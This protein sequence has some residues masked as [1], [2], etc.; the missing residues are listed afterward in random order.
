MSKTATEGGHW[1]DAISG[2]PRYTIIGKNGK[3]RNTNLGDARKLGLVPSVTTVTKIMAAPGL[4]HYFKRQMFDATATTP[5]DQG[6]SDDDYFKACCKWAD[7]HAELARNAGTETHGTIEKCIQT[8]VV[9]A[10]FTDHWLAI[11]NTLSLVNVDVTTG[12]A[13]HSF[14][15][16]LGYGGKVD[17][18]NES[19]VLDFKTKD[20]IEDGKKLAWDEH[21]MQLAAYAHG[22]NIEAPR[23]LN[24]FVGITDGKVVVHE[25]N[26]VEIDNGLSL[27]LACLHLWKL[28]NSYNPGDVTRS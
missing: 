8:K 26:P 4:I 12:K 1:Y 27:F 25:W 10:E 7:E 17:W 9:P 2:A 20:T 28:K 11:I 23:C 6:M 21:V 14:A 19:I 18:H 22:L 16:P 5:R 13:E 15:S 24:V 3:E